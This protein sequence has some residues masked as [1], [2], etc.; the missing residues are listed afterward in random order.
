MIISLSKLYFKILFTSIIMISYQVINYMI[1]LSL[2]HNILF[3]SIIVISYQ[4][5]NCMIIS[6]LYYKI[7]FTSIIVISY[8][9]INYIIVCLPIEQRPEIFIP[10][11]QSFNNWFF[12]KIL[13]YYKHCVQFWEIIRNVLTFFF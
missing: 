11:L 12:K 7:L 10:Y 5:I 2:Y 1:I 6:S 3:T 8:Q 4:V 13:R 9:V